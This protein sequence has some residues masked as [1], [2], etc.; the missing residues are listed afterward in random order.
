MNINVIGPLNIQRPSH[1]EWDE[2]I[3]G[4][5]YY[6]FKKNKYHFVTSPPAPR[7]GWE[8]IELGGNNYIVKFEEQN[9]PQAFDENNQLIKYILEFAT[10]AEEEGFDIYIDINFHK[11]QSCNEIF[12]ILTQDYSKLFLLLNFAINNLQNKINIGKIDEKEFTNLCQ[13]FFKKIKLSLDDPQFQ[14]IKHIINILRD[15][16]NFVGP[17]EYLIP[18][19]DKWDEIEYDGLY[20]YFRKGFYEEVEKLDDLKD[21]YKLCEIGEKK[22]IVCLPINKE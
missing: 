16:V 13:N 14:I 10:E 12:E 20:Y 2:I 9:F 5:Q 4:T 22:Y 11:I 17:V 15:K 7:R 21:G 8:W 18:I 6:Y 1:N 19:N 3:Y